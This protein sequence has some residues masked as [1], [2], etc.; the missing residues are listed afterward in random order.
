MDNCKNYIGCKIIKA[1]SSTYGEYKNE[2]YG[3][4]PFE[5]KIPDD[6][7]GYLVIYPGIGDS[8]EHVSWSPKT[9]FETA[10]REINENELQ[11]ISLEK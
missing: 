11:F 4:A 6:V 9:V 8:K 2:K 3:D 7:P 10:Y 5:S 1:K